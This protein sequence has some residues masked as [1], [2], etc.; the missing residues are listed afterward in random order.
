MRDQLEYS[1][2]ALAHAARISARALRGFERDEKKP[3][4]ATLEVFAELGSVDVTSLMGNDIRPKM[5]RKMA[6]GTTTV[7]PLEHRFPG[8]IKLREARENACLPQRGLAQ[9]AGVRYATILHYERGTSGIGKEDAVRCANALHVDPALIAPQH[10]GA[11]NV[12]ADIKVSY[13]NESLGERFARLRQ[14]INLDIAQ[15]AQKLGVTVTNIIRIENSY[16]KEPSVYTLHRSA[17]LFGCSIGYLICL[18]NIRGAEAMHR[19]GKPTKNTVVMPLESETNAR[20]KS[21]EAIAVKHQEEL[22]QSNRHQV[23]V[24][25]AL[26]T[27]VAFLRDQAIQ[28][29]PPATRQSSDH[30]KH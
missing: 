23:E 27:L 2:D 17:E 16:T 12:H 15:M 28:A 6:K 10:F 8:G 21:L 25:T 20:L 30:K 13:D 24:S 18:T 3:S 7:L 9:L 11:D 14:E 22:E 1:V 26:G 29:T 4:L 5:E 19:N